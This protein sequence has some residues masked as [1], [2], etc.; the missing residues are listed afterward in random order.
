MTKR[1]LC[2]LI[3][4]YCRIGSLEERFTI[5]LNTFKRPERLRI[6]IE[7]YSKCGSTVGAIRIPWSEVGVPI[8]SVETHRELFEKC[9]DVRFEGPHNTTS[10]NNRFLP[11][12]DVIENSAIFSVDDDVLVSCDSLLFA[13]EV[14]I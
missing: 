1:Y 3:R 10:I 12:P 7:H 11:I 6:A 4:V 8:P 9:V 2:N 5:V 13:F 14:R